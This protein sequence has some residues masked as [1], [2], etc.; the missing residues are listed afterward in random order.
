MGDQPPMTR[1]EIV[2]LPGAQPISGRV[3]TARLS[4]DFSGWLELMSVIENNRRRGE[5]PEH[6]DSR[7]SRA[8]SEASNA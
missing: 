3:R 7:T 6:A 4:R 2:M 8:D 5:N 1:I